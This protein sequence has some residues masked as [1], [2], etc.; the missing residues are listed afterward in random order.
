MARVV[1]AQGK[2][3][4]THLPASGRG[5]PARMMRSRMGTPS[6][7]TRRNAS[8]QPGS[9]TLDMS[10]GRGPRARQKVVVAGRGQKHVIKV[11]LTTRA[12]V[13]VYACTRAPG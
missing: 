12:R 3:G 8:L 9:V 1:R 7:P 5:S 11:T 10:Y 6:D 13:R 2:D 4:G